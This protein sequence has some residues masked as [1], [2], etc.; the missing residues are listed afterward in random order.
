[1]TDQTDTP[2]IDPTLAA[3]ASVAYV[4]TEVGEEIVR[5]LE[6]GVHP[7]DLV[8]HIAQ[9]GD[10]GAALFVAALVYVM[11]SRAITQDDL[12]DLAGE[13]Y[14]HIESITGDE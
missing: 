5:H 6:A 14:K 8:T 12:A 1:M 13:I 9:V 7:D 11:Q 2:T 4:L 10:S 3:L